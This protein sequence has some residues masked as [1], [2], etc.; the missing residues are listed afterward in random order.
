MSAIEQWC[1][2]DTAAIGPNGT[3]ECG[4]QVRAFPTPARLAAFLVSEFGFSQSAAEALAVRQKRDGDSQTIPVGTQGVNVDHR[5][6]AR[7][8]G[9]Y[10]VVPYRE[11][12][13]IGRQ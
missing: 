9:W 1:N 6:L 3:C 12:D 13:A 8:G 7:V 11:E 4:A 5:T 2:H 10:L